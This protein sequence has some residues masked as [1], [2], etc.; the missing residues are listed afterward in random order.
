MDAPALATQRNESAKQG[1]F[2][3]VETIRSMWRWTCPNTNNGP[4]LI[5]LHFPRAASAQRSSATADPHNGGRNR[6]RY[7]VEQRLLSSSAAQLGIRSTTSV[8]A[9]AFGLTELLIRF[10][11]CR[12]FVKSALITEARPSEPG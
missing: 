1:H 7:S 3:Q 6:S 11:P 2:P 12:Q 10:G 5:Q 9:I 8:T 4:V